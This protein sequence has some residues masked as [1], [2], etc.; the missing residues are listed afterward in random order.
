MNVN[1]QLQIKCTL[2]KELWGSRGSSNIIYLCSKL[3]YPYPNVERY[4]GVLTWGRVC[5]YLY[6]SDS[7]ILTF[8][9]CSEGWLIFMAFSY[10]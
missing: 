9:V 5:S 7:V 6:I 1:K 2:N 10:I 4:V 8:E 3:Y